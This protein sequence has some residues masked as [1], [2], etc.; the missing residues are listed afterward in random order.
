MAAALDI[1]KLKE[2]LECP[3]CFESVSKSGP[4]KQCKNGHMV[5]GSCLPKL[6]NGCPVCREPIDSRN[7]PLEKIMG[8]MQQ[9]K[10]GTI[11]KQTKNKQGIHIMLRAHH[12]KRLVNPKVPAKFFG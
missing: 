6:T 4:L 7:L 8:M 2:L 1:E 5:C 3:I 12:A 11:Q 10:S 9:P